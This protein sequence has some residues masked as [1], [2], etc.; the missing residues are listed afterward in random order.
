MKWRKRQFQVIIV[1]RAFN[2]IT[3]HLLIAKPNLLNFSFLH[4]VFAYKFRA[5]IS[6]LLGERHVSLT[7]ERKEETDRKLRKTDL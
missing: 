1:A 3:V 7:T 6:T 2:S 4:N 5:S